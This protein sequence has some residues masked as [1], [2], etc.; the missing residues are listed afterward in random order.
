MTV[1]VKNEYRNDLATIV[2]IDGSARI[3]VVTEDRK[4]W[5]NQLPVLWFNNCYAIDY[6]QNGFFQD[7]W[8]INK[9]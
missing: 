3:Q 9:L 6:P 7:G 2:H 8:W 1:S 5:K 4:S